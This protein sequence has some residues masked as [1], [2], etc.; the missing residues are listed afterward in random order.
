M[1]KSKMHQVN[2]KINVNELKVSL[3]KCLTELNYLLFIKD[4]EDELQVTNSSL[5]LLLRVAELCA[6]L[7]NIYE[8]IMIIKRNSPTDINHI[9]VFTNMIKVSQNNIQVLINVLGH[10]KYTIES[11][12]L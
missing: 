5:L 3:N 11:N 8:K 12:K 10:L 9:K 2:L 1:E 6:H 7:S 4:S